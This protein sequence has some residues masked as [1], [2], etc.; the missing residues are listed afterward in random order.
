MEPLHLA[1]ARQ[2]LAV[3]RNSGYQQLGSEVLNEFRNNAEIMGRYVTN[4]EEYESA[5]DE[6]LADND[7]VNVP[8]EN[9]ISVFQNGK[10]YDL[11]L[12]D[13]M[14]YAFQSLQPSRQGNQ[15]WKLM[16]KGNDLFKKL[17][18]AYNPLFMITNP[19]RDVQDA[20]FYST[21]TKRWLRNYPRAIAQIA[22][23]GRFWQMY[24]AMGG[25]NNSY[26]DWATGE[27]SGKMG[28]IEA[29]NM[30]IEQAPRLAEYM[31][32]L[33]NAQRNNGEVTQ[34]DRM[35]AFNAAAE[36][37]TNFSRGGTLGK[38]I[39]RNLVPFWNPGVQGLSK[40]VRTV[41]ETRGFK[42]WAGLTM[43]AAAL[44]MVPALLNGLLYRDDDEWDTIDDQLKMEYYLFKTSDGVWIKVPKG[45]VL[46]ALSMPVIGAQE[47]LRGDEVDW[48]ELT[49]QAFGSVA[50]NNPLETNLLS[51]A[52]QAKLFDAD[53]P[54]KT[55]YGGDIESRRLQGYAPGERYDEST[56]VLSKWLGKQLNIS[57]KKI[58]YVIDQYSGILG[59]LVLPYLTP[60]AERG[61]SAEIAGHDVSVPLSNA[62]MSRFTLDTVTNNTISGEYYDMLDELGF[63]AKSGDNPAAIAERYMNR[64]GSTVSDIY[65][66]IREIENDTE[67]TDREKT[68][69]TQEL[70]K[71]LNEY[72][73]Q[74]IEDAGKY[75]T[76]AREYMDEHPEFDYTDDGAVDAFVE[77]YNSMQTNEK[78]FIDAEQ[79]AGKMKD[80]VYREVN[81]EHFGAEYALQV[82]NK[83][84]YE[85]ART[86]H[87]DSGLS[88]EDYYDYYFGTRYLF[89][90]KDAEGN[91]IAGSRTDKV[92]NFLEGMDIT[93]EQRNALYHAADHTWNY[94]T[95]ITEYLKEHPEY[96]FMD[97]QAV[98][99]FVEGYNAQ[100][101]SEKYYIDAAGAKSKMRSEAYREIYREKYGAEYALEFFDK[102]VYEK[103][104]GL[105]TSAGLSYDDYYDFYFG[106]RYMY[107]DKDE[108]GNSIS[109]SKKEKVVGFINDMDV[110]DAEK[111]ALYLAAGY[112]ENTLKTTP[113]NG[114]SGQYSSGG[115]SGGRG[116]R[117]SRTKAPKTKAVKG[118]GK[119]QLPKVSSSV[120]RTG[121]GKSGTGGTGKGADASLSLIQIIDRYYG[122]NALAAAMDGGARAR[123]RTTV[124]FEL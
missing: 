115:R 100:Q 64:A 72:E 66:Q 61:I 56:D 106:T 99:A 67:L 109:G 17:C 35:E 86:V 15:D 71:Q 76:S 3:M 85:K 93:D 1:L 19:I 14:S 98:N 31:T 96:D 11:T 20:L 95:G 4:V 119:I 58:N 83:D 26:F 104:Q 65:A 5:W 45:R 51:T 12:S 42:A 91:T 16:M 118:S 23:N 2:T 9:V 87:D 55:W 75:L 80:E 6:S 101:S 90:D 59:D 97:S 78:Y 10:R 113:W 48:K 46:A 111:D 29:L 47:S 108:N 41:T 63:D 102:D 27:N 69:L 57:P 40:A 121:A 79:A 94:P 62:F 34:A 22:G 88:Y 110:S 60:R 120:S 114:G 70:R 105:N 116:G 36:I 28:R 117:S 68:Q 77:G 38:W 33:E 73:K 21:D 82:Y 25:V 43:K 107:A 124:D 103:A 18:T 53:D 44:G 92:V 30:A 123:G 7:D 24:Q 32:V 81:R 52:V 8:Y 89:G 39:N 84:V 74:V 50:P 112:K 54:G 13:D 49:M 122:G 37:T